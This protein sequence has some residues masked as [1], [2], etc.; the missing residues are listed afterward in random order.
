MLAL[1]FAPLLVVVHA[2]TMDTALTEVPGDP[3][4]GRA[5]VT[6]R[7]IGLCVLCHGGP[8]PNRHLHGSIAPDL[9]GVGTRL[10]PG[11]IRLRLVDPAAANPDSIMPSY[12]RA[13]G[14]V[15]PGRAFQDKAILSDAAIEDVVAFLVTLKE[16]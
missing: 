5:I 7:Q 3:A 11:E 8:F 9:A 6:T 12:R 13:S 14:A 4:R 10:T 16:D 15:R 1:T 2:Q